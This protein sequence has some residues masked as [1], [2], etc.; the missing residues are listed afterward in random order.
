MPVVD[1][2]LILTC[3][4]LHGIF[5]TG[6]F[7]M[8]GQQFPMMQQQGTPM[9]QQGSPMMQQ[10]QGMMMQGQAGFNPQMYPGQ[11]NPVST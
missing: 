6:G 1:F 4:P 8:G 9:M 2:V 10:Q 11:M 3:H 5:I 7:G